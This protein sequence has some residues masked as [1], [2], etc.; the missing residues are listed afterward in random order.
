MVLFPY[1]SPFFRRNRN[2][3]PEDCNNIVQSMARCKKLYKKLTILCHPDKHPYKTDIA[4]DIM[5]EINNN[6]YNYSELVKLKKRIK[7]EL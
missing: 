5:N 7:E 4:T 6:R 2:V 1:I 3:I